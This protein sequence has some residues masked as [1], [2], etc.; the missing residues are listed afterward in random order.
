[1][2]K[3]IWRSSTLFVTTGVACLLAAFATHITGMGSLGVPLFGALAGAL[4]GVG[5]GGYLIL[6][7]NRN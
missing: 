4:L 3:R 1:M 7:V 2:D 5:L 6:D